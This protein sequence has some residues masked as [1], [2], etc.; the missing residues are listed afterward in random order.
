VEDDKRLSVSSLVWLLGQ[1]EGSES[2][3]KIVLEI[4]RYITKEDTGLILASHHPKDEVQWAVMFEAVTKYLFSIKQEWEELYATA[5]QQT[6]LIT[7]FQMIAV[8]NDGITLEGEVWILLTGYPFDQGYMQ[9][10]PLGLAVRFAAWRH[11]RPFPRDLS[12]SWPK[13]MFFDI[14]KHHENK[15]H[16]IIQVLMQELGTRTKEEAGVEADIIECLTVLWETLE[17]R[18]LVEDIRS[19]ILS[20]VL[21]I[22]G[23]NVLASASVYDHMAM[24]VH[25]LGQTNDKYQ[26]FVRAFILQLLLNLSAFDCDSRVI[27]FEILQQSSLTSL[28]KSNDRINSFMTPSSRM[29]FWPYVKELCPKECVYPWAVELAAAVKNTIDYLPRTVIKGSN[30]WRILT[31]ALETLSRCIGDT[32][33]NTISNVSSN[34]LSQDRC[35]EWLLDVLSGLSSG[36]E[37]EKFGFIVSSLLTGSVRNLLRDSLYCSDEELSPVITRRKQLEARCKDHSLIFAGCGLLGWNY[38]PSLPRAKDPAWTTRAL[39]G[40][41]AHWDNY[42]PHMFLD[43]DKELLPRLANGEKNNEFWDDYVIMF[44]RRRARPTQRVSNLTH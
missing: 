29:Y 9:S 31:M 25:S 42:E 19:K 15:L 23:V 32:T 24:V 1:I 36:M 3:M 26:L 6:D 22:K 7:L 8:V 16:Y 21:S 20:M 2:S 10:T 13:E 14:C 28:W 37:D 43:C 30:E 17:E 44:L 40:A 41:F 18:T 34:D 33:F 5:D 35:F 12:G 39:K 4:F 38:G 27:L 11:N